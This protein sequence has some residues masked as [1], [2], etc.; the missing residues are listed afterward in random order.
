MDVSVWELAIVNVSFGGASFS[1]GSRRGCQSEPSTFGLVGS[2]SDFRET[3]ESCEVAVVRTN[4]WGKFLAVSPHG[5]P[6]EPSRWSSDWFAVEGSI[7][8]WSWDLS[9]FLSDWGLRSVWDLIWVVEG[10][11]LVIVRDQF[12]L[13]LP[14]RGS[15]VR[16]SGWLS[17]SFCRWSVGRHFYS[18]M[19]KSAPR[20]VLIW[21]CAFLEWLVHFVVSFFV[22]RVWLLYFTV[23][24]LYLCVVFE[25]LGELFSYGCLGE[26]GDSASYE[27]SSWFQVFSQSPDPNSLAVPKQSFVRLWSNE[28]FP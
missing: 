1:A 10:S 26:D 19:P 6:A 22:L 8:E 25:L 27:P 24:V 15:S 18:K 13:V 4:N 23:L 17:G 16:F 5:S 9:W 12:E 7:L 28:C 21:C 14:R 3:F 11:N 2:E 20:L